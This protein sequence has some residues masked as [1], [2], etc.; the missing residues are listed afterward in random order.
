MFTNGAIEAEGKEGIA[1]K[2]YEEKLKLYFR[3]CHEISVIEVVYLEY[4]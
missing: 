4:A 1:F 2:I 3:E